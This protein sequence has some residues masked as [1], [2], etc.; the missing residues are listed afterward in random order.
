MSGAGLNAIMARD[1]GIVNVAGTLNVTGKIEALRGGQ[2]HTSGAASVV[3]P[4]TPIRVRNARF[5]QSAGTL[6][7]NATTLGHGLV[8]DDGEVSLLGGANTTLTGLGTG[9]VGALT[10]GDGKI[11]YLEQ[12]T[13][14]SGTAGDLQCGT[15]SPVADTVLSVEGSSTADA[16]GA[17]RQIMAAVAA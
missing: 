8:C 12:P 10:Y 5:V 6:S 4:T 14:V 3:A 13:G 17:N 16:S 2:V 11:R 15:A 1:S 7:A 9:K